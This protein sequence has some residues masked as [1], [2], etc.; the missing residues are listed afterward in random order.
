MITL[1]TLGTGSGKPTPE[2]G[3]SCTALFRHGEVILFDCGEGTQVQLT[4]ST[5]RP[6][7]I[8]LVCITHFHGDHING[9]PGLLGTLQ[10]NQRTEPLTVIGPRGLVTY[11]RALQKVGALG[12]GYRL[13][14]IEVEEPGVVYAEP[15]FTITAD[16]LKHRIVC[17]GY[18]LSEPDR[19]GRFDVGRAQAL[20]IPSGPLYG[21]LQRGEAVVLPDGREVRPEE[22][23]GPSRR[24][25]SVAYCLDTQ[26]CEGT[27]RLAEGVDLLVH[28]GTYGP[29]E[30]KLAHA[31]GHST[32]QDAAEM[33]RDAGARE[34]V[35][36]HVSPKIMRPEIYLKE[37][38]STFAASAIAKD[39][40][41][42]ELKYVE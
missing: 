15:G 14:L 32:M 7:P 5:L 21:R 28:E 33:A 2:R 24:G 3:V 20:S 39:F 41:S 12:V 35:I 30:R 36:T 26:P 11:I 23:L 40:D 34:L 17:W 13:D 27:L 8:K 42:F 25:L 1:H 18:R 6:G 37:V 19:P 29:E 4:R 16:R 10:L 38:Q 31:R 9:L 22:V